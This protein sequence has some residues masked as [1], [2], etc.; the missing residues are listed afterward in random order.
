[1]LGLLAAGLHRASVCVCVNVVNQHFQQVMIYVS[2]LFQVHGCSFCLL[3][4]PHRTESWSEMLAAQMSNPCRTIQVTNK[5]FCK[6]FWDVGINWV[7]TVW[8]K[9]LLVSHVLCSF[10]FLIFYLLAICCLLC[11]FSFYSIVYCE[12]R[13]TSKFHIVTSLLVSYAVKL[14]HVML[15]SLVMHH[16]VSKCVIGGSEVRNLQLPHCPSYI[17]RKKNPLL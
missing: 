7:S 4:S 17:C 16:P 9:S 1:M 2:Q 3:H 11:V 6:T 14:E 5:Y 10:V 13:E 15:W 12:N 8:W